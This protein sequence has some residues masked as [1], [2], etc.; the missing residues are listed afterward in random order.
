[1]PLTFDELVKALRALRPGQLQKVSRLVESFADG[2]TATW[3]RQSDFASQDFCDDFGDRLRQH[4]NQSGGPFSKDK[5]EYGLVATLRDAGRDAKK[6]PTGNPG[7]DLTV[8]GQP[9]SLKTQADRGIKAHEIHISKF[10]EL[11]K[12][13]WH[14]AADVAGLRDR[15]FR[16]MEA[17]DR[18]LSLRCLT[19]TK[20]ATGVLYT[21]ELVEIPKALL[22][23]A[24]TARIDMRTGSRQD[25]IPAS[26]SVYDKDGQLA[27]EA[28]FDGGTER[29]LQIQKL[30]K[31]NCLVHAT[32]TFTA[33]S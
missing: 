7:H 1:M 9:W 26:C 19:Q 33:G 25:P 23:R 29:K 31:R 18:I 8:N 28:Y 17:Y 6:S 14:T 27:F 20:T 21:Y 4:H 15:W 30:A 2:L 12:G 3:S 24:K 16:H 22:L 10:M 11:G 5:F 32:W 13:D